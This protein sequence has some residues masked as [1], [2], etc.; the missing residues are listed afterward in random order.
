M[1]KWYNLINYYKY[2]VPI[3]EFSRLKLFLTQL[4]CFDYF[5]EHLKE[6]YVDK[7]CTC[8]YYM[9]MTKVS[10]DKSN[11][12]QV[13]FWQTVNFLNVHSLYRTYGLLD[14][15]RKGF[16]FKQ[17]TKID[18]EY[19]KNMFLEFYKY[20]IRKTSL[21]DSN[22]MFNFFYTLDFNMLRLKKF[23]SIK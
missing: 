17:L 2:L 20:Y 18:E 12:N 6:E 13:L 22:T 3:H 4:K 23:Y 11:E 19:L 10:H 9:L 5:I 15:T 21:F 14:N 1:D 8:D 7:P 16:D